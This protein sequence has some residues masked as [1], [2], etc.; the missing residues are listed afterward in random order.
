MLTDYQASALR[1]AEFRAQVARA[2]R[3]STCV[4]PAA[5]RAPCVLCVIVIA[6]AAWIFLSA[7]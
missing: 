6:L 4:R 7:F 2:M 1:E 3:P 5:S